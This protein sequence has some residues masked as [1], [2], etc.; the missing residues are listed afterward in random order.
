MRFWN[1]WVQQN[2]KNFQTQYLG[3]KLLKTRLEMIS[4]KLRNQFKL[5]IYEIVCTILVFVFFNFNSVVHNKQDFSF[6]QI[7]ALN[8]TILACWGFISTTTKKKNMKVYKNKFA[9]QKY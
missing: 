9:C 7:L 1:G 3:E 6:R 4:E 5:V 8:Y 2:Y